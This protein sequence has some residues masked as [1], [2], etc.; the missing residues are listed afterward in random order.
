[1]TKSEYRYYLLKMKARVSPESHDDDAAFEHM[2]EIESV[3]QAIDEG[4]S[5]AGIKT[6]AEWVG[7]PF[8]LVHND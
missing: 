7:I 8:L 4:Q 1:M 6:A 3:I 5:D 2:G